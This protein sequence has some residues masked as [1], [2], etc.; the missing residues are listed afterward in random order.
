MQHSLE[1]TIVQKFAELALA[2]KMV[3]ETDEPQFK[4]TTSTHTT[5]QALWKYSGPSPSKSWLSYL[6]GDIY[7]SST[8]AQEYERRLAPR[9]RKNSKIRVVCARYKMPGWLSY[10]VGEAIGLQT[11]A[12]WTINLRCYNIVPSDSLVFQY[13][14]SGDIDGLWQLFIEN[15]ASI[16]DR[17]VDGRTP[18]RLA[19]ESRELS[20]TQF[21][22]EQGADILLGVPV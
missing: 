2:G 19:I 1:E 13:A 20:T 10:K 6:L 7:K 14:K 8:N 9:Q 15:K 12:G 3:S 17:D 22:L 21:L 5:S 16:N 11:Q 18:L 4:A